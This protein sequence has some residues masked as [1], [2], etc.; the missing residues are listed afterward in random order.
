MPC[1]T[2][3]PLDVKKVSCHS[4]KNWRENNKGF[5]V[6]N[7]CPPR[8]TCESSEAEK[9]VQ[10]AWTIGAQE[11]ARKYTLPVASDCDDT[12]I[13][14]EKIL[15]R[16]IFTE[17]SVQF[18]NSVPWAFFWAINNIWTFGFA[19]TFHTFLL[20]LI[21]VWLAPM[22]AYDW[23]SHLNRIQIESNLNVSGI[24]EC[25]ENALYK[26]LE[27]GP[28]FMRLCASTNIPL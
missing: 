13:L 12:S 17:M 18:F 21:M 28:H 22:K 14:S 27:M 4:C 2:T 19:S 16:W 20:T 5:S 23:Y 10:N 6:G 1:L 8:M 24:Q 11:K 25:H 3:I 7:K 9:G 15:P 26:S